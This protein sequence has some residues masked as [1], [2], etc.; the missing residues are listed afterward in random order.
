MS[1]YNEEQVENK[2]MVNR[3]NS[4]SAVHEFEDEEMDESV[5]E[6]Q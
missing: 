6:D 4:E 1:D 5:E 2:G 3:F